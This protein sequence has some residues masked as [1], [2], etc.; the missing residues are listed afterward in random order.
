MKTGISFLIFITGIFLF[1]SCRPEKKA[2]EEQTMTI[3]VAQVTTQPVNQK[4]E[5][6]FISKPF[7]TSTLSFRVS[8]PIDRFDVFAGNF[9]KKGE[10]IARIDPRDFQIRRERAEAI[11]QQARTEFERIE[12]LYNKNNLSASA[13]EKAKAELTSARTAYETATN[14]LKDTRL[15]APFDGYVGEVFIEQYQD[16][17]AT[18]PILTFV[19]LKQ[20]RIE[21]FVSQQVA[22]RARALKQ[23]SIQ[24]NSLPGEQFTGKVIELS[25]STTSNNLSYLLTASISNETDELPA[26]MSGK[27]TFE[28]LPSS[29]SPELMTVIPQKAV[30]HRPTTGSYVWVID[31]NTMQVKR[32]N[33]QTG[34]LLPNGNVEIHDGLKSG[35]QVAIS[36]LRFLSDH[37]TVMTEPEPSASSISENHLKQH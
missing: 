18:Q 37:K 27:I 14:E 33:I 13:F 3:R 31:M 10:E 21:A 12:V 25:K 17:K 26:G 4:D 5:F 30:C 7:R 9:Y 32:R 8:G 28:S 24:F 22:L 11:Y 16:V 15:I 2:T 34:N 20:L 35:E 23:V 19:D 6:P 36:G 29:I 1:I